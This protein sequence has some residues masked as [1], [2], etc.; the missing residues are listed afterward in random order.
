MNEKIVDEN[1]VVNGDDIVIAL[2]N[3]LRRMS[4]SDLKK[5]KY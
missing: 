4:D 5:P 3:D 1:F 2:P